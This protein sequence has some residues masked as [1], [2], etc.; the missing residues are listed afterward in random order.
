M[1][2]AYI[3]PFAFYDDS[4]IGL[5]VTGKKI[6]VAL[7]AVP[8][9]NYFAGKDK[10]ITCKVSSWQRFNSAILPPEAKACGNYL[11]SILASLEAKNAGVDEAIFLYTNGYVAEGPGENIFLV[12]NGKLITPSRDAPILLGITRDSIIKI[13]EN[14]GITVEERNVHREELY[15]SNEVFFTGTAVEIA[16]IK[17]VDSREVGNGKPGPITKTLVEKYYSIVSGNDPEFSSWLT[18]L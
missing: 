3:R 16:P 7:I 13:A 1:S 8:F 9:G 4:R 15:T 10:G 5:D 12:N 2:T 18:Y 17:K 14:T 11:N 6:S